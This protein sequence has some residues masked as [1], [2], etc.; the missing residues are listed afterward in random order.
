MY[1]LKLVASPPASRGTLS[2]ECPVRTQTSCKVTVANPLPEDVTVKAAS[3]NKQVV[4]PATVVLRANASTDVEVRYRPLVVGASEA[5]LKLESAELGLFEWG[6]RLAGTP[7]NPE[8]SLG[9]NVPLGGRETQVFRFTHWLD[10]KA[11]YK[12]SFKSSGTNT[13]TG[14]AFTAP[15]TVSATPAASGAGQAGTEASLE[16]AFEPTAIGENIRDMLILTSAT[17]GEYQ[18][19]LV[20]R[21]IPPKPQGPVDVSKGSA[22][23]P[24]S[25]VFSADADFQLAVDN[26]AFQVKPVERIGSK[27]ASNIGITFKPPDAKAGGGKGK[28]VAAAEVPAGPVSRTGKLTISCPSQTSSQWVYY[29]QA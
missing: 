11:D 21:C 22:A 8:R 29:L 6:L 15:P 28:D 20:G 2:L 18:C 7:T 4:V 19:P 16:V 24:F 12:V 1:E 10:E 14:G 26:P 3:S 17:G 27:K 25:N 23:L 9:F 13:A 5:T